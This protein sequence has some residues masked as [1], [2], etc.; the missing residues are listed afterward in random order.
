MKKII[1]T[2]FDLEI[3]GV[4]R[5]L[6]GLLHAID[7]SQYDVDLFLYAHEGEF[8]G[9][10]PRHVH[11][12]PQIEKYSMFEKPIKQ[13]LK[14]KY[15]YIAFVRLLS[16]LFLFLKSKIKT[17][18]SASLMNYYC[19]Y[20][21]PNLPPISEHSYDLGISFLAPHYFL[22]EHVEAQ[23]KI[24][25]IHTDYSYIDVD[26]KFEMKM[27]EQ[28]DYI[29][30]V[31]ESCKNAFINTFPQLKSKTIVIENT[32][33]PEFVWQQAKLDVSDE[34]P[35]QK[36]VVRLCTVGRFSHAKGF[37]R[38][39]FVCKRLIDMGCPIRWYAIGYGGDEPIIREK[40]KETS[41]E[42][43]FIILGKKTNPY[44][45]IKA[46]DIYIQPSRYE[47]KAVTVREAQMLYKPVV[48]TNFATAISQLQDGYDG[49]IVPMDIEQCAAGIKTVIEDQTLQQRLIENMK[50]CNY[51]NENEVEK[52]YKLME[53]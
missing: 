6:I 4:E 17:N 19:K 31:S 47:G 50:R 3:G 7:Y 24:A 36:G 21:L 25:W 9:M 34:M 35:K 13:V 23:K 52:I 11:L 42:E 51:G 48:I 39:V 40:I 43:H 15:F 30:A 20:S 18:I 8:M 5:S 27:W 1:I 2:S 29:P 49:I 33:S 26:K 14:Q 12:L 53:E 46:C 38:A 10:I 28:F 41:M 32:L 22:L 44:P 45:Y 16:K 37:D